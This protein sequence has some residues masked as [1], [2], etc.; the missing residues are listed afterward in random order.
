MQPD[1]DPDYIPWDDTVWGEGD[2]DPNI[3]ATTASSAW[4]GLDPS[5]LAN[6]MPVDYALDGG[7]HTICVLYRKD[8]GWAEGS[9]TGFLLIPK[10][11]G[12]S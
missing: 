9:D 6:Y 8:S 12:G 5:E 10:V 4:G 1:I 2:L 11:Q 7:Q 3:K